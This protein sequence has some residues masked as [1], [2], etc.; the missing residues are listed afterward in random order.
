MPANDSGRIVSAVAQPPQNRRMSAADAHPDAAL[1][2]RIIAAIQQGGAIG[3][4]AYMAA[5]LGD[6]KHGYYM[7][8]DPPFIF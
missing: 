6:A 1:A 5:C 4:D 2:D 7:G 8:K 3:V